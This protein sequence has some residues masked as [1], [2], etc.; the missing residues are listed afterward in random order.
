MTTTWNPVPPAAPPTT[1]EDPCV[2]WGAETHDHLAA[3]TPPPPPPPFTPPP[4]KRGGGARAALAGLAAVGLLGAGIATGAALNADHN[5]NPVAATSPAPTTAPAT[6]NNTTPLVSGTDEE[7]VAAV[8][9]AVGPSVVQIKT[10]EGLG[11]GV[12]YDTKG[13]IMTNAHVVGQSKSV[14]VQL[15]DGTSLDGTVVGAD[16]TVD[17]A[18]VQVQPAHE[19]AAAHLADSAPIV[20]QL[21]VAIGSPFGL[22]NSVTAGVVSAINRPVQGQQ[23]GVES[24]I[25]TD[26]PINPGNSGG[27][28]ANR[29]GEVIG[30]NQQIVSQSGEN[31]GIGFAIPIAKA[32][33]TADQLLNGGT[34]DHAYLGVAGAQPAQGQSG[35]SGQSS[36][37]SATGAELG[38]VE[39]N[40][41][42]AK[43]GLK[44]GDVVVSIDG[45]S[46]K[47]FTD[48]A[49]KIGTH[50]TGDHVKLEVQRG[51]QTLTV[52]VTLGAK[53]QK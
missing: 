19:L 10:Q 30:I 11:S 52:D 20:G 16:T 40:S 24:E 32:K 37:S 1:D 17:I 6:T 49:A 13:L 28:L 36:K 48:L 18:V 51:G 35:A 7:P 34:V 12:I 14:T 23:G 22:E 29:K 25:Q 50:N 38:Q 41:P 5:A 9:K 31:N 46:V 3:P 44:T 33:A 21:T 42:A 2:A 53:P 15:A 26:A 39:A 43:A 8:A 47:D 4:T 45:D 27:A